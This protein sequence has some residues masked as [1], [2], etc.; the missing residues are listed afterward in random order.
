MYIF[1]VPI[2]CN[3]NFYNLGARDIRIRFAGIRP[4]VFQGG[5]ERRDRRGEGPDRPRAQR[6]QGQVGQRAGEEG[7]AGPPAARRGHAADGE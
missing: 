4:Q 2:M 6:V 3:Q 1:N 7:Q 5:G